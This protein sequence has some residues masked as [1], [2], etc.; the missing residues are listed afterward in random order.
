V[1]GVWTTTLVASWLY[2]LEPHDPGT[3]AGSAAVLAVVAA[4][5][6]WLPVRR[7]SRLDPAT[8]LR[9]R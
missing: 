3:L 5:A 1:L 4:L 6:S 7:A 9:A 8:L 2:G